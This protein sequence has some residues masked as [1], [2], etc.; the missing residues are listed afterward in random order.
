M[1]EWS[2]SVIEKITKANCL[3]ARD[4]RMVEIALRVHDVYND[5]LNEC[6]DL[7][8]SNKYELTCKKTLI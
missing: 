4:L 5:I 2:K 1:Y 7:D 8:K 3:D 6:I